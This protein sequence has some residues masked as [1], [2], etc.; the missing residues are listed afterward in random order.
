M[1]TKEYMARADN[2][3]TFEK[4]VHLLITNKKGDDI[5]KAQ[6]AGVIGYVA[7][8]NLLKVNLP[9]K[10]LVRPAFIDFILFKL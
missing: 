3:L 8:T 2:E 4:G 1:T 10:E 5:W 9:P 7:P 6:A